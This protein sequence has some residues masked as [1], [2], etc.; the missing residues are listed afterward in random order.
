MTKKDFQNWSREKILYE[1]KELSKRKKFGI[2][3]EDKRE[4]AAEQCKTHLPVLKEEKKK[5]IL[6][7]NNINHIFIQGDNYH[8]LSVLNYTHKR[9]IDIIYIDPP[10][11]TGNHDFIYNDSYVDR[12]DRYRHS[13]WLSFMYK[14]LRL[15]KHLLK[16]DGLFFVSI[17]DNE[18]AQLKLICDEVFGE[19]NFKNSIVVSRVKKNIQERDYAKSLNTGHGFVLFYAMPKAQIVI[20]TKRQIKEERWHA[21]DAPG[22]R[23]TMEY[24]L[25][26]HKPPRNRHWMFSEE[27]A[28]ELIK[29]GL[30]RPSIKSS[31]PQYK[32]SASDTTRLD[33]NWT[34]LQEGDSKWQFENGEKNIELIKRLIQMHPNKNSTILDFFAGSGTTAHAVLDLNKNYDD[35]RQF[36]VCTDNQDNNGSGKKIAQDIAYP[37]IKKVIDGHSIN[38]K[39]TDGLGGGLMYLI[40]EFVSGVKTDNDKRIFTT[41]CAEMLC[42]AEATFDEVANK[43]NAFAIYDNQKQMTGIIYDEDAI[44]DFKKEAKKHKKPLVIYVFSYDHTYNEEDFEGL[45]NLRTVKPIPEVIL[46]VYRKIYKELYK[47]RNL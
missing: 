47:P 22:I 11:N 44:S 28:K 6:D 2:V 46:N 19:L 34:D 39:K 27:K 45:E 21:F 5:R 35:K 26:G 24:E 23:K 3:W 37:R 8:A 31:K 18:Y 12:E 15:A 17:D 9:K 43:K 42:L 14:R 4:E 41:K 33:T 40:T 36:I 38:G 1:Y 20:P 32:L 10:Y 30:L 13:K 25:F 29:S 7:K 16:D